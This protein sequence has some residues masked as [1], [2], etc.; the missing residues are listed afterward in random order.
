MT[1]IAKAK[2]K[3]FKMKEFDYILMLDRKNPLS[4]FKEI[5]KTF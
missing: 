3:T 1:P 2:T 4:S 5:P